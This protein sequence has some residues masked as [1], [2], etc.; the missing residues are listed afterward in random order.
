M[1]IASG[2]YKL[3]SYRANRNRII[4]LRTPL[5]LFFI[6]L[7]IVASVWWWLAT[8]VTLV[9]APIDPA[10]KLE[11]VS[12]APFRGEQTPHDPNLI[13][14]PEQISE[15]LV[16]LAKVSKCIRTYSIDNGLDRVPELASK[17]G[18]KVLL[19]V[20]LGR[21]HA[22]NAHLGD[23]AIALAKA[24]VRPGGLV[25]TPYAFYAGHDMVG[26]AELAYEPDGEEECWIYHFF[27]DLRFQGLGYGKR[28]LALLIGLVGE[29]HPQCR[30]VKL[31]VHP[32]NAQAQHLYTAAGFRPAGEEFMEEPVYQLVLAPRC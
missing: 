31:T 32:E 26:F 3:L 15:D 25:W 30:A 23:A 14:S 28:A 11:C 5:A 16:E 4:T 17:A 27:I 13:V 18:L 22:K 1:Q 21:D 2:C 24:Y 19:G 9:R 29:Q 20:W 7:G 6:S 12:Y 8:P 10:A